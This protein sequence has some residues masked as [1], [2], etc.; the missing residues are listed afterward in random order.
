MAK[1]SNSRN[2]SQNNNSQ[3]QQR[4]AK[5]S[6]VIYSEIKNGKFVGMTIVNAWKSTS[7]GLLTAKVAPYDK[8]VKGNSVDYVEGVNRQTGE[9]NRYIKML[10]TVENKASLV[11]RV[12]PCL[13]NVK[14]RVIVLQELG[15]VITPN[16]HG[17]T[18]NG[19]KVHG[20][21]GK[22]TQ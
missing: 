3:Q 17:V 15:Y 5:R 22:F 18:S 8:S 11:K 7:H 14:T 12:I 4:A 10:A 13:M 2:N 20:Y 9:I 6:G 16:G 19:K 21:F 1:Y